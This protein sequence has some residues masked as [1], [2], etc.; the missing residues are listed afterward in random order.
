MDTDG[1]DRPAERRHERLRV[2]G[3]AVGGEGVARET[4]GRVVFVA[5][6]L[7]GELVVAEVVE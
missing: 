2:T 7:P 1:D 6:G 5:G 3:V 4:S